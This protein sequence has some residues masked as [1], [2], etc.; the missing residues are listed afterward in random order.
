MDYIDVTPHFLI[1]VGI[2]VAALLIFLT[3]EL[4]IRPLI[5]RSKKSSD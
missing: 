4:V 3:L 2:V 1:F 5:N